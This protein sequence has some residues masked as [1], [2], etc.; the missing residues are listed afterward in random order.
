[1]AGARGRER[2]GA[3]ADGGRASAALLQWPSLEAVALRA[4]GRPAAAADAGAQSCV[5]WARPSLGAGTTTAAAAQKQQTEA[6]RRHLQ[7][8]TWRCV[9]PRDA[10]MGIFGPARAPLPENS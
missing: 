7:Y 3:E 8:I 4:I 2:G 6:R 5:D 1:M 10:L 9:A